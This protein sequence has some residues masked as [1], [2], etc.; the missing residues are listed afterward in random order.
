MYGR[1]KETRLDSFSPSELRSYLPSRGR[2]LQF[3]HLEAFFT[4]HRQQ[5]SLNPLLVSIMDYLNDYFY[6][7]TRISLAKA[8]ASVV[9]NKHIDAIVKVVI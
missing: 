3:Y 6:L 8:V 9:P 4:S 5:L 2:V 7:W 1:Q